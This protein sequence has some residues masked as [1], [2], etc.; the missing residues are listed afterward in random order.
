MSEDLSKLDLLIKIMGMTTSDNDNTALVAVRKAQALLKAEGWDWERLLRAKIKVVEDP[1]N[2]VSPTSPAA[3]PAQYTKP[4]PPPPPKV[5]DAWGRP[6]GH[7]Q[8]GKPPAPKTTTVKRGF[9]S[10]ASIDDL[11]L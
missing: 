1:F 5:R 10:G 8:Y 4:Y 3:K 2:R 6:Q 9:S 11:E 7:P